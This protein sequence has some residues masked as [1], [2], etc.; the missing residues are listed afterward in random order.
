MTCALAVG[1]KM[2]G[3]SVCWSTFIKC[4]IPNKGLTWIRVLT[5]RSRFLISSSLPFIE[6][7]FSSRT[8]RSFFLSVFKLSISSFKAPTCCSTA[9]RSSHFGEFSERKTQERFRKQEWFRKA[10]SY[11]LVARSPTLRRQRC[12]VRI[13]PLS[14]INKGKLCL[15][16][17]T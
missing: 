11:Q 13:R 2:N 17:C 14:I 5:S 12:W 16:R 7:S 9:L 1:T 6:T 8:A 10:T 3:N 15:K 4:P